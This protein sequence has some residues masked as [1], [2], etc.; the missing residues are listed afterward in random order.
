MNDSRPNPQ[1]MLSTNEAIARPHNGARCHEAAA[2][3]GRDDCGVGG[4][5]KLSGSLM[6]WTGYFRIGCC[7]WVGLGA[8]AVGAGAGDVRRDA[9]AVSASRDR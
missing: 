8:W 6:T 5:G 3:K 7:W 2:G 9:C 1:T 4:V